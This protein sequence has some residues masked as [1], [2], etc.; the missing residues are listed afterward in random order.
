ML[1]S[2]ENAIG[3][4]PTMAQLKSLK[5]AVQSGNILNAETTNYRSRVFNI[6]MSD[7]LLS[8]SNT[9][10]QHFNNRL[11]PEGSIAIRHNRHTASADG[12]DVSLAQEQAELA[13]AV[14]GF[15]ISL[16]MIKEQL[17]MM[18]RVITGR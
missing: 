10:E 13:E 3:I 8:L 15:N 4:H 16:A 9:H 2:F 5:V 17:T 14:Q 6:Q 7:A 12:N 1:L 18:D 11:T